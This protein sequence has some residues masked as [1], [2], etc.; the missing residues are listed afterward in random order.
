M[1]GLVEIL[2]SLLEF[3]ADHAGASMLT[4]VKKWGNSQGLR[5]SKE[6]LSQVEI[7][8]GDSIEVAVREGAIVVTPACRVRGRHSLRDLVRRIPKGC[9]TRE[10]AWGR[11]LGREV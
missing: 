1:I 4:K 9:K 3:R 6:L 2:G 7:G 8:V 5:L 11:A 10:V